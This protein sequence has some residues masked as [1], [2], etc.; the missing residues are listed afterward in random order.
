MTH[1]P[2]I[3]SPT[4]PIVETSDEPIKIN[5]YDDYGY[6]PIHRAA[7]NGHEATLKNILEEAQKRSE[8]LI[9]LESTTHDIN[10]FTPLLL[11]TVAGRLD[12]IA[13]LLEYPVNINAVDADGHGK[14]KRVKYEI[15]I[16]SSQSK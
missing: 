13:F 3:P 11:A 7:F 9:Q 12:I 6:L 1:T 5:V 14:Y 2:V 10:E 15:F 8:V 4:V 16:F